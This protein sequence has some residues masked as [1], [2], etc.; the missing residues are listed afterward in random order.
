MTDERFTDML[1]GVARIY[2]PS[3]LSDILVHAADEIERLTAQLDVIEAYGTEE[4]NANIEL[5]AE[6]ARLRADN[7]RENE[8]PEPEERGV[9][10][11]LA[12]LWVSAIAVLLWHM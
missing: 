6:I 12:V 5:R 1:R 9:F 11:M 4:I 2:Y 7:Q 10:V 3:P 8:L